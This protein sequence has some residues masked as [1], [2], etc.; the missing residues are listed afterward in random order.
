MKQISEVGEKPLKSPLN[1][2]KKP[3]VERGR[4]GKSNASPHY[5]H[6]YQLN[7]GDFI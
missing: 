7:C 4:G 6:P 2:S 1:L 5:P 3:V